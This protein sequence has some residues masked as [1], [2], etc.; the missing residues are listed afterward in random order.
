MMTKLWKNQYFA[1]FINRKKKCEWDRRGNG[2]E[3]GAQNNFK[4][5]ATRQNDCDTT[6]KKMFRYERLDMMIFLWM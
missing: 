3:W 5:T 2:G 4:L 6:T 1:S